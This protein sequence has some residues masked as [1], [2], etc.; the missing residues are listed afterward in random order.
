MIILI[1][2]IQTINCPFY[3]LLQKIIIVINLLLVREAIKVVFII[4]LLYVI[5]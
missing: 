2:K 1:K 3:N 4:K 5:I